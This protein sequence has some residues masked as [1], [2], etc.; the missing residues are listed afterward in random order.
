MGLLNFLFGNTT[1]DPFQHGLKLFHKKRF[2]E[3]LIELN[4]ALAENP[5]HSEALQVMGNIYF[6]KE[7]YPQAIEYYLKAE[8]H[9][10]EKENILNL[11]Y[12]LGSAYSLTDQHDKAI[13]AFKKGIAHDSL[14]EKSAP[15]ERGIDLAH[16]ALAKDKP[17]KMKINGKKIKE[18][19]SNSLSGHQTTEYN[20]Y[21]LYGANCVRYAQALRQRTLGKSNEITEQSMKGNPIGAYFASVESNLIRLATSLSEINAVM[22]LTSSG[23]TDIEGVMQA[24]SKRFSRVMGVPSDSGT[25]TTGLKP[26][27]KIMAYATTHKEALEELSS[28]YQKGCQGGVPDP[29]LTEDFIKMLSFLRKVL[30]TGNRLFG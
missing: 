14:G 4:K 2:D 21:S 11:Q 10:K 7:K 15:L 25:D 29:A 19:V 20:N 26:E 30:E 9:E 1:D 12:M 18:A 13:E 27:E 5:Q 6:E 16:I 17:F 8:P 23:S 3:A 22:V 28:L 24:A